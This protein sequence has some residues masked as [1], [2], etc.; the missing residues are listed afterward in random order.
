V[1]LKLNKVVSFCP[2][3][4]ETARAATP[5]VTDT[6]KAAISTTLPLPPSRVNLAGRRVGRK[7]QA[8]G[9]LQCRN[10]K[11]A[12]YAPTESSETHRR[13]RNF[14]IVYNGVDVMASVVDLPHAGRFAGA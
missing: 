11:Q 4:L 7:W 12:D 8:S 10:F 13:S 6:I 3:V 2:Q 9:P 14:H 1:P 5:A